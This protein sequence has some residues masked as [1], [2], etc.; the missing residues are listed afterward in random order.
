MKKTYFFIDFLV[1]IILITHAQNTPGATILHAY[2]KN[3]PGVTPP[4]PP[5]VARP[6]AS[7]R[8]FGAHQKVHNF[9]YP[10]NIKFL[11]TAL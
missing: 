5:L 1:K 9:L 2:F 8:P 4:E 3:F 11:P 10:P 6:K 7:R